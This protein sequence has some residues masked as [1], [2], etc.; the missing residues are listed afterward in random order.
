MQSTVAADVAVAVGFGAVERLLDGLSAVAQKNAA[1]MP[2]LSAAFDTSLVRARVSLASVRA[3]A[4]AGVELSSRSLQLGLAQTE[5]LL[6]NAQQLEQLSKG[7]PQ[8][9]ALLRQF[10]AEMPEVSG[11][12]LLHALYA[13]SCL[14]AQGGPLHSPARRVCDACARS[15]PAPSP[16]PPLTAGEAAELRRMVAYATGAYGGAA[17]AVLRGSG[18]GS[19]IEGLRADNRAGLAQRLGLPLTDLVVFEGSGV[20]RPAHFVALDRRHSCVVVALR[21]SFNLLDSLTNLTC[22]TCPAPD[23]GLAHEGLLLAANEL[24]SGPLG[25]AVSALLAAHP[26]FALRICGHSQGAGVA[27]LLTAHFKRAGVAD[28]RGYAFAPPCLLS[29]TA[30]RGMRDVI[31]VVLGDDIICRL[32]MGHVEDLRNAVTALAAEPQLCSR[33]IAAVGPPPEDE[34]PASPLPLVDGVRWEEAEDVVPSEHADWVLAL[35]NS[36]HA[37]MQS[38][39]LYPPGRILWMPAQLATD[40]EVVAAGACWVDNECFCEVALSSTLFA[41]HLPHAYELAVLTQFAEAP[42]EAETIRLQH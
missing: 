28:V 25:E 14:Q 19:I 22:R 1:R 41:T 15:E 8:V 2:A 3:A 21:G 37:C 32:S 7:L 16:D 18:A 5:R 23:G 29:I 10:A 31:S 11:V 42:S 6:S 34:G 20:Y 30:A 4:S 36:L 38:E 33:V 12:A 17:L 35:R 40:S 26:D 13:L 24:A 9:L 39:R 27:A